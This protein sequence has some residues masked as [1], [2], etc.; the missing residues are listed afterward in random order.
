MILADTHTHLYLEHFDNDRHEAVKRALDGGVKYM[1]LPNIDENTLMHMLSLAQSFPEHLYPMAG[2]H[3][4]SV[5]ASYKNQLDIIEN[6]LKKGIYCAIGET[7]I[8]LYWDKTYA[9]EQKEALRCQIYMADTYQ[10]PLVLH[11]RNALNE[12]I[13]LLKDKSLPPTTGVFH[14]YPGSVE[15]ARKVIDL[16][17]FIGV[18]G[19]IT[20]KNCQLVDVVRYTGLNHVVLETDAP[21]LPPE[22][23][24][25]KRN[26]SLYVL[27][28]AQKVSEILNIPMEEVAQKTTDNARSLFGLK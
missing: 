18:G 24:R 17:Y 6:E 13:N 2:L 28:V 1:L 7:G 23:H 27:H 19:T 20:Y 4:T 21:F 15:D 3:P 14:C 9:A 16:G 25:G 26:E 8:D 12:I 5:K 22:P 10:L 11:S